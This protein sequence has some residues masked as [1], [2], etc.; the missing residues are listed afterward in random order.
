[1][2]TKAFT[3][4]IQKELKGY[5]HWKIT[6]QFNGKDYSTVTTDSEAIDDYSMREEDE[7]RGRNGYYALRNAIRRANN[8]K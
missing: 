7:K 5:G 8:I 1:M 3:H 6:S 2:K 4:Y